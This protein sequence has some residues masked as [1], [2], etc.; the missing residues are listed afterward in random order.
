MGTVFEDLSAD[1][2]EAGTSEIESLCMNCQKNVSKSLIPG[3]YWVLHWNS[4]SSESCLFLGVILLVCYYCY[5]HTLV[6][7]RVVGYR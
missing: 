5:M 6:S 3:L 7:C 1:Q 4:W 2:T